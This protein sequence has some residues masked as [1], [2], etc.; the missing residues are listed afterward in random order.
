MGPEREENQDPEVKTRVHR[1]GRQ[2]ITR[3]AVRHARH[4]AN[5]QQ[6]HRIPRVVLVNLLKTK[7]TRRQSNRPYVYEN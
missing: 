7:H 1:H 4:R 6:L 3:P 5:R 2:Q